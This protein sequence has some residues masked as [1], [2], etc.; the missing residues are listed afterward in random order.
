MAPPAAGTAA[1]TAGETTDGYR[2]LVLAMVFLVHGTAIGL[3]WQAIPPL[4]AVLATDVGTTA[5][6][7][8]LVFAAINFT[9]LL[10]QLPGGLLGDRF[11]LRYVVGL[12][13]V[14]TGVATAARGLFPDLPGLLATSVLAGVGMSLVNPNPV[15]I[16]TEWFAA[17]ELGLTQGVTIAGNTIGSGLAGSLSAGALLVALGSWERVFLTYGLLTAALGVAWLALVRS[18]D[19]HETPEYAH[20]GMATLLHEGES[21]TAALRG[22]FGARSTLPPW[23][24]P[25][26]RSG[27][28]SGR[29]ASS[30]STPTHSRSSSGRSSSGRRCSSP[31]PGRSRSPCS[32]SGWAARRC[33]T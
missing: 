27:P 21:A 28:S 19:R 32:L 29:S 22:V 16:V 33:S 31:R 12:G 15:K 11:Q 3:V 13:A 20:A 7:V 18:P 9:L 10:F 1:G 14:L 2:W 4:K 17:E 8:V 25:P 26:S 5:S 23:C 30:L 24:S 6:A